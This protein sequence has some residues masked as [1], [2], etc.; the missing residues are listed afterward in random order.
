MQG[1]VN[2]TRMNPMESLFGKVLDTDGESSSLEANGE[3]EE[4]TTVD[5][6]KSPSADTKKEIAADRSSQ[7]ES[8]T[9]KKVDAAK[10]DSNGSKTRGAAEDDE[11]EYQI[12]DRLSTASSEIQIMKAAATKFNIKPKDGIKFL[13]EKGLLQKNAAAVAQYLHE[14]AGNLSKKRIG[15]LHKFGLPC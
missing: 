15:R 12:S 2:S 10:E 4:E 1:V 13:L 11:D 7:N 3:K 6:E 5:K 14:H 8:D 9:P